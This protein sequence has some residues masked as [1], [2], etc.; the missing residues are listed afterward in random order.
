MLSDNQ[1]F[2]GYMGQLANQIKR[3]KGQSGAMIRIAKLEPK[4]SKR[5]ADKYS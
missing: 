3:Q 4:D 2:E 1:V 5:V